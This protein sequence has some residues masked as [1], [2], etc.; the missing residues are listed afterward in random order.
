VRDANI[1]LLST[2]TVNLFYGPEHRY[3]FPPENKLVVVELD[4]TSY[5]KNVN[6]A[7]DFGFL[8]KVEGV[9]ATRNLAMLTKELVNGEFAPLL[10]LSY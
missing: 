7:A 1:T 4:V 8:I 5:V 6:P 2:Q 10:M 9:P 3:Y